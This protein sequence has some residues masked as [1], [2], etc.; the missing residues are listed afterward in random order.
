MLEGN[1]LS[2]GGVRKTLFFAVGGVAVIF[3]V[4]LTLDL[5]VYR[6]LKSR[7]KS[8]IRGKLEPAVLSPSFYL[9]NAQLTWKE[10]VKLI[11]GDLKISYNLWHFLQKST[12]RVELEGKNLD[13]EFLGGWATSQG[14]RKVTLESFYADLGF[15]REGLREVYAVDAKSPSFQ[16]RIQRTEN[17]ERTI[18]ARG[19]KT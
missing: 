4:L 13:V 18:P 17:S 12:L 5:Q 11:S 8:S 6:G 1:I 9:R 2:R 14:V 19:E 15:G 3:F 7:F 16:F 10:K